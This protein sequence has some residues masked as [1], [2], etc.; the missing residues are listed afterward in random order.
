M[1]LAEITKATLDKPREEGDTDVVEKVT[2]IMRKADYA[3]VDTWLQEK[4]IVEASGANPEMQRFLINRNLRIKLGTAPV[5]TTV[6]RFALDAGGNERE[7]LDNMK[8]LIIPA[9]V[10]IAASMH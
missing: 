4:E 7:Y 6:E 1:N 3:Q 2:N 5:P 8:K 9:L 10:K